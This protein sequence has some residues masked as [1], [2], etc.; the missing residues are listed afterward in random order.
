MFASVFASAKNQLAKTLAL[1]VRKNKKVNEFMLNFIIIKVL[2]YII[3][4]KWSQ[5]S[6]NNFADW[7]VIRGYS[8][9]LWLKLWSLTI[10]QK[11]TK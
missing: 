11:E 3:T 10:N 5:I 8:F 4:K 1:W 2:K 6:N 7:M 9:Q